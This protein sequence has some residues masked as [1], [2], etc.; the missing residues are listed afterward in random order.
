MAYDETVL[1]YAKIQGIGPATARRPQP[2]TKNWPAG[3]V[4]VSADSHFLEGDVWLNK[5]PAHLRD[6][7][8]RMV[9]ENGGWEFRVGNEAPTPLGNKPM[10]ELTECVLGFRDV[11]QRLRDLDVE[12]VEKELLFPQK[13]WSR[14]MAGDIDLREYVFPIHNEQ[15]AEACAKAPGRLY[16]TAVPNYW[17]VKAARAS[18]ETIKSLGASALLIPNNGRKDSN[19]EQ[20]IWGHPK[21][22]P[23]WEAV[24]ESGLPLAYHVGE[25]LPNPYPGA[26]QALAL[27]N[28]RDFAPVWAELS[29]GGVFDRH[30]GLRI[31]FTEAGIGWVPK[32]LHDAD[33]IYNTYQPVAEFRPKHHP[34][35]YWFNNCYAT[36]MIDPI[37]LRLLDK[38]GIDRVMWST[39]YPHAESTL[40]FTQDVIQ[41]ILDATTVENAQKI[42]GK[43]AIDVF[44]MK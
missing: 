16:F 37:G 44:K 5:F 4:I 6:K 22:A 40:G 23:F 31:V 17:D 30:P 36:F 39:D 29:F 8:P 11:E 1:E 26:P 25:G 24:E 14:N 38:I 27:C 3:T 19:G 9:F 7:A 18:I 33:L 10:C 15:M 32:V 28:F 21:M 20:I 42:L 13:L 35:W 12:G 34:S 41:S 43:T 2:K